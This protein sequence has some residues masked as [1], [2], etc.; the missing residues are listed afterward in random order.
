MFIKKN[1]FFGLVMMNVNT[2]LAV[3]FTVTQSIGGSGQPVP[4]YLNYQGRLIQQG[5]G[6]PIPDGHHAISI[7]IYDAET[8]GAPLWESSSTTPTQTQNGLF[9]VLLGPIDPSI[10]DGSDRWVEIEVDGEVFSERQRIVSVSYALRATSAQEANT[11][12]GHPASDFAPVDHTHPGGGDITAVNPG[13]GLSGGGGS[14]DVTL[15]IAPSGI[16]SAHIADGTIT[17]SDIASNTITVSNLNFTPVTNPFDGTFTLNGASSQQIYLKENGQT[18]VDLSS[19]WSGGGVIRVWNDL[20]RLCV[21]M[22]AYGSDNHYGGEI[23]LYNKNAVETIYL[24]GGK[25]ASGKG[26]IHVDGDLEVRAGLSQVGSLT[27]DGPSESELYI[28]LKENGSERVLLN[29]DWNGGGFMRF[30]NNAGNVGVAMQA[31]GSAYDYGGEIALYNKNGSN[32]IYLRGGKDGSGKGK[33]SIDGDLQVTG[34]KNARVGTNTYGERL[35]YADESAEV[36]FFDRSKGQLING[37]ATIHLDAVF[38]ETVTIDA[39]NPMI[40]QITPTANC[41]GMYV[42]EGLTSFTVRE[43]MSG[44]SNATF[45]WEVAAKR[46]GYEQTRLGE[47]RD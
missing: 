19:E 44:Q 46:R 21:A 11:L 2:L 42:E 4:N 43:L 23:V 37:E 16:T 32:T 8:S 30:N 29:N 17:G 40:V 38:L 45:N 25:D 28:A 5:K 18:R 6:L 20:K 12:Q 31:Y 7:R 34:N 27:L 13:S 1:T 26:V 14:G 15:S 24:R 36:Y 9:D 22:Q 39:E 47:V 41:R 35:L 3:V 33:I 10:F